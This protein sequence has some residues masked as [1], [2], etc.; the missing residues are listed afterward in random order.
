MNVTSPESQKYLNFSL[1]KFKHFFEENGSFKKLQHLI[2]AQDP[3]VS[4]SLLSD[5]SI[6]GQCE[7]LVLWIL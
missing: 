6:L 5:W 4:M 3:L 1:K 2:S 7:L